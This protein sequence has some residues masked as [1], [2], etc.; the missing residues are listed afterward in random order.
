M[1]SEIYYELFK[2][3]KCGDQL[4]V[5]EPRGRA[6]ERRFPQSLLPNV[7]AT[8]YGWLNV[9]SVTLYHK[10][11]IMILI[12]SLLQ[13]ACFESCCNV[14]NTFYA[15][16]N[17]YRLVT[18][19]FFPDNRRCITSIL[20]SSNKGRGQARNMSVHKITVEGVRICGLL[21]YCGGRKE[22]EGT[23]SMQR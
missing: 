23:C 19:F 22:V 7:G 3:P 20:I 17:V 1:H 4:F 12:Q 13:H 21:V 5:V 6:E 14:R 10:S 8:L 18:C 2:I 15:T 9:F 11:I 16:N